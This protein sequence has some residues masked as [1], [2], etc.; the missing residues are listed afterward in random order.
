MF[1][2]ERFEAYQISIKFLKVAIYLADSAPTGYSV[3]K[4]QFK[5]AALSIPLNIAEGS[6][7]SSISDKKRF[8]AI[9]RGSAM[10]CAAICDVLELVDHHYYYTKTNEAKALLKSI[11]SIL[12][13][14]CSK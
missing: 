9:A 2:H 13:T 3:V 1:G 12:T 6:G 8:Y 4:D 10:E 11:V 5:R 14:I 7:K